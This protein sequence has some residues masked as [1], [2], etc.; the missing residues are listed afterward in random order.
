MSNQE[1]NKDQ[2]IV[3]ETSGMFF[4]EHGNFSS[5]IYNA[6]VM[7]FEEAE[8]Y[9]IHLQL[10]G[11]KNY[12]TSFSDTKEDF[13]V[14]ELWDSNHQHIGT[15]IGDLGYYSGRDVMLRSDFIN[16]IKTLKTKTNEKTL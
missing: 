4:V 6:K 3:L 16:A 12:I 7:G 15:D 11:F 9:H 13:I 10:I 14:D 5:N 1:L 2:I 8:K